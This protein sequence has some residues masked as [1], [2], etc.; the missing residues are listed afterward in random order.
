MK[1]ERSYR[2][3]KNTRKKGKKKHQRDKIYRERSN[4]P[5]IMGIEIVRKLVDGVW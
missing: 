4:Q 3:R 5:F 2:R 1:Y